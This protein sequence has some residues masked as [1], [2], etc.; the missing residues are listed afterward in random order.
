MTWRIEVVHTTGFRYAR[1]VTAS[2]NETRMTP[3]TDLHQTTIS[4]TVETT[5]AARLP[6][7]WDS[8]GTQVV[9]CD[10]HEPHDEL[11]VRSS[12]VV[13]TE[14]AEQLP[15]GIGWDEIGD[16]ERIDPWVEFLALTPYVATSEEMVTT[17]RELRSAYDTPAGAVLGACA[18]VH[19]HLEYAPGTTSV[20][21]SSLGALAERRGVCQDFAHVTLSLMRSMGV[22]GRYV[23]GYL[24]P[25][26]QSLMGARVQGE[27][28]AWIEAWTGSWWGQ[29]PT[30]GLM[31]DERHVTVARGRDYADVA[32]FRGTYAGGESSSLGVVVELTRMR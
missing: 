7:Y 27:S 18:W 9:A 3:A 15:E 19:E 4:S 14:A 11:V 31:I 25:T 6:R 17:A 16:T 13:E 28:H 30:N 21:T 5:P 22:P 1:P 32:P 29:D 23:S 2:Y 24:Y 26:A 10:L 8:W 12:S 20:H